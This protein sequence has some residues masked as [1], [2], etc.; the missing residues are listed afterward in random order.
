M[1]NY[2]FEA[3]PNF[4]RAILQ[5]VNGTKIFVNSQLEL[6]YYTAQRA[7]GQLNGSYWQKIGNA[8]VIPESTLEIAQQQYK[9]KQAAGD[10]LVTTN[11]NINSLNLDGPNGTDPEGPG[12]DPSGG[13]G[14]A[15]QTAANTFAQGIPSGGDIVKVDDKYFIL[16]TIPNTNIFISYDATEQDI[17]VCFLLILNSKHLEMYQNKI[18]QVL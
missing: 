16:Y 17:E 10:V 8:G 14:G 5:D 15:S 1:S 7:G 12:N 11:T 4:N 18:Y 6:E 2:V 13:L 3:D 9:E